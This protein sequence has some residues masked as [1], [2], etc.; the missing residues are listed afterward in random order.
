MTAPAR[1]LQGAIYDVLTSDAPFM[2]MVNAVYDRIPENAQFPYVSFGPS[3]Y[4]PNDA[5]CIVAGEYTIQLDV[6]S[7]AVGSGE[8]YDIADAAKRLIH[9]ADFSITDNALSSIRVTAMRHFSDPDGLTKH[10]VL[11]IRA[12]IEER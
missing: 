5:A 12:F 8:A 10:G 2:A 4:A 1:E 7:R 11:T 6:W 3:S 9:H